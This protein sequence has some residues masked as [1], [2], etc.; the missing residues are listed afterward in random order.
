MGKLVLTRK[1]GQSV[2]VGGVLFEVV[3]V[4][5]GDVTCK[6]GGF[7]KTR[8]MHQS[9]AGVGGAEVKVCNVHGQTVKFLFEAD[10]SVP[11]VR[12]ELK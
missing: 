5:R 9:F 12:S 4:I 10:R 8:K 3:S 1:P 2:D 11:I 7:R 6:V